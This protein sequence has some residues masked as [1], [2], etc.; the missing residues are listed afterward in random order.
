MR[1]KAI[2]PKLPANLT[3]APED[4]GIRTDA[5]LLFNSGTAMQLYEK[6]P[7]GTVT[8]AELEG[9]IKRVAEVVSAH[10]LTGESLL[11]QEI[12][13]G[14]TFIPI[15]TGIPQLDQIVNGRYGPK[16]LEISGDHG[17]GKTVSGTHQMCESFYRPSERHLHC[18]PL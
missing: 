17:T 10:M 5:D 14:S 2:T 9:Y 8:L 11:A 18:K 3:T 6:L 13:Q 7:Q 1:L 15:S 4:S 12:E 16:V